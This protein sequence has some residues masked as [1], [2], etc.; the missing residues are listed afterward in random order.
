METGC[1]NGRPTGRPLSVLRGNFPIVLFLCGKLRQA[2]NA[3]FPFRLRP[4]GPQ[5]GLVLPPPVQQDPDA[6]ALIQGHAQPPGGTDAPTHL[7]G[8]LHGQGRPVIVPVLGLVIVQLAH[9]DGTAAELP[10]G[11]VQFGGIGKQAACNAVLPL[12]GGSHAIVGVEHCRSG[13]ESQAAVMTDGLVI[14]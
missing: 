5:A 12:L 11:A 14:V 2:L 4:Q 9:G 10:G 8:V 1:K 3:V 13:I 6:P 7:K